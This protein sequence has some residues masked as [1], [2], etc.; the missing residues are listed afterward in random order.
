MKHSS[1]CSIC[2]N[3]LLNYKSYLTCSI[4]DGFSHNKCNSLSKNDASIII[5]NK[6]LHSNWICHPCKLDIFPLMSNTNIDLTNTHSP[7]STTLTQH[8]QPTVLTTPHSICTSCH[9]CIGKAYSRCYFC[10]NKVHNR[11]NKG[12]MGCDSCNADIF[13][14]ATSLF[15][16]NYN[17]LIFNP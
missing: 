10:D 2:T 9:K 5:N 11:C 12:D 8:I 6:A 16:N 7:L 17:S 13:P 1:K 14:A 3:R 15:N 4:C